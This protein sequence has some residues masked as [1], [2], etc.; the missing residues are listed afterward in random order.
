MYTWAN[1]VSNPAGA[2]TGGSIQTSNVPQISQ[3]LTNTTNA[4]ATLTYSVI[5]RSGAAGNCQGDPFNVVVNVNAK[6]VIGNQNL[7]PICSGQPFNVPLTNGGSTII[8]LNTKY[9]WVV[10][11]DNN[12]ITGQ[13][14]VSVDQTN[15]SQTLTN[16]TNVVQPIT[17]R[18]TPKSGATG[19]CI[20]ATFLV[21]VNVNPKPSITALPETICSNTR[22]TVSPAN[23][24]NGI[25][26][27]NTRYTWAT[28]TSNPTSAISGGVAQSSLAPNISQILTNNSNAQATLTY[29]V[30]PTSGAAGACIGDPF[31]VEVT[32]NPMP[33]LTSTLTPPAICNETNFFYNPTSPTTGRSWVWTRN[34][35]P[36]ITNTLA[37]GTG[38]INETLI[39]T[40]VN[41]IPVSYSFVLTAY[42]CNN[43]QTVTVTVNPTPKLK[44]L[45]TLYVVVEN[46]FTITLQ[47]KLMEQLTLGQEQ[48]K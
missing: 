4:A 32:V 47:V 42:G 38:D 34:V 36:G 21:T 29:R 23:G 26:P 35:T 19:N 28:P 41:P 44:G 27:A 17:Y 37:T 25:V 10:S 1:P 46:P 6:P 43:P 14:D 30:T 15:I 48:A 20:G 12:N 45:L 8:P 2:V 13:S 18:V 7:A 33:I 24:T 39:N 11:T 16:N 3:R 9:T 22:F 31:N 5:P 40:T